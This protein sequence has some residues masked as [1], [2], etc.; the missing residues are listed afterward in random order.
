MA[1]RF[2]PARIGAAVLGAS[3]ALMA[4]ALP[5]AAEVHARPDSHG[6]VDAYYVSV[7]G[8]KEPTGLIGLKIDDTDAL[9]KTYC[10]ELPTPVAGDAEMAEVPWD[11]YP[12]PDAPFNKN[13]GKI[14]WI[15]AN[16]YP[17][18]ALD[19]LS[20]KIS[21][22]K[23]DE[24]EAISATQAA[25]WHFS[26]GVNLDEDK[27]VPDA[28]GTT[29]GDVTA[30]YKY[31]TSSATDLNQPAPSLD[32]APAE[33]AGQAGDLIGPFTVT[34]TADSVTLDA[35]LPTGV[36]LTD[37]NGTEL[38]KPQGGK[39][40]AKAES[41]E[42]QADFYV[43]VPAGAAAGQATFTI[44]ADAELDKGRLF[45]RF[46]TKD[47]K[48]S[49][50][51]IVASPVKVNLE[52]AAK[53]TWTAQ[54]VTTTTVAPTTVSATS[55]AVAA[56]TTSSTPAA[57]VASTNNLAYTG[58]SIFWPVLIGV[59]LVAAGGTALVLQRRKKRA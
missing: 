8:H 5:A 17:S 52:K 6:D 24:K 41:T 40:Q 50:S 43:K 56:P 18:V 19:A 27:S 26:D 23:L 44:K 4:T 31:L 21:G 15:L 13:S 59:V 30:L 58:A 9:V 37:K 32:L 28:D 54:V 14:N 10:V 53:A 1:S 29:Q 42:K 16:S 35:T 55:S 47:N 36:T 49:Q 48:K 2:T 34:T 20:A 11:H 3:V 57:A 22:H 12:N 33:K 39:Y 51:L 7:N 25:I 38:P 45:T 46:D